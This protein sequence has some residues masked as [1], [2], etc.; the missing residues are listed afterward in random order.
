M[1]STDTNLE[2][3]LTYCVLRLIQSYSFSLRGWQMSS[4]VDWAMLNSHFSTG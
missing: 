1:L 3:L 2:H 4:K